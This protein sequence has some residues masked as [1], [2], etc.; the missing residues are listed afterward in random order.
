[1][2][3]LMSIVNEIRERIIIL[4]RKLDEVMAKIDEIG[5]DEN[6]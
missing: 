5:G 6:E 3:R 2:E 1:M 4:S